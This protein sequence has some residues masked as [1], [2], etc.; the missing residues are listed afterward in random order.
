MTLKLAWRQ[1]NL[2]C[3]KSI[4]FLEKPET[5]MS[6]ATSRHKLTYSLLSKKR[7]ALEEVKKTWKVNST[8]RETDWPN[9]Y[10]VDPVAEGK[11]RQEQDSLF[12][13][14]EKRSFIMLY[15]TR[16]SGKSTRAMRTISVLENSGYVCN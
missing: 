16:A 3:S 13:K 2:N 8:L 9:H 12:E 14:I 11:Q 10:F 6:F 15:G 7:K 5:R 4:F 1:R